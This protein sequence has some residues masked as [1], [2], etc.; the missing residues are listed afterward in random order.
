MK[1]TKT[2]IKDFHLTPTMPIAYGTKC[3]VEMNPI[4]KQFWIYTI[5]G[6]SPIGKDVLDEYF[7]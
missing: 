3:E 2:C 1:I 4:D 6:M 5:W 7:M